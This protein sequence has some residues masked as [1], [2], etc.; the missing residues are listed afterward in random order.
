[1][2]AGKKAELVSELL[3]SIYPDALCELDF[4]DPWQLL[5][6]TVLSAQCT[7]KRVN[8]V[9]PELFDR[10]PEPAD[11]MR[12]RVSDI[13]ETIHSTG[14]FRVKARNLKETAGIIVSEFA[15]QVPRNLEDMISLP[16]V[17][18]KTA[19]VVLGEAFGIA[20][21]IAVDTHVNRLSRRLGLTT[22]TDSNRISA[23]LEK[24]LDRQHWIGFSLRL[25]LHGRRVC[26]A[27]SPR[28]EGCSLQSACAQIGV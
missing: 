3:R 17:G 28:C 24:L 2:R 27:R 23:E 20:A 5:V 15:G 22:L 6:A 11:L 8:Q 25:V 10:W 19:K 21:G 1:M 14:F 4:V 7:D 12:A 9:T 26:T 16:G 18:R 13:E